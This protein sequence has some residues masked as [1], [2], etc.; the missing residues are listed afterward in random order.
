MA[1]SQ[2]KQRRK[3]LLI[4]FGAVIV[5]VA[6]ITVVALALALGL[7]Y[8]LDDDSDSSASAS[9]DTYETAAVATDAARCSEVGVEILRKNGSAVDAAIA[10]LLCVGVINMHSTGIGGGGFLVYYNATSKTATVIDHRETAPGRADY[11]GATRGELKFYIPC[12]V[13]GHK[14]WRERACTCS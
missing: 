9:T 5:A 7:S 3:R 1:L 2:D 4:I 12:L 10:S 11:T 13:P 14:L 6:V 8:G